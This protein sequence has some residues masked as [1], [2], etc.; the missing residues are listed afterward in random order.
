M[1]RHPPRI[2]G[3]DTN[4]NQQQQQQEKPPRD[5][6]IYCPVRN[7][8][9]NKEFPYRAKE[10]QV[11]ILDITQNEIPF[12]ESQV[13]GSLKALGTHFLLFSFDLP[14]KYRQMKIQHEQNRIEN[15]DFPIC[16]S[17][18]R[19]YAQYHPFAGWLKLPMDINRT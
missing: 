18:I 11:Y 1:A 8:F 16:G 14:T 13:L 12:P 15:K 19:L 10:L 6:I 9:R 5:R 7:Q 3:I 2:R 17:K 4:E